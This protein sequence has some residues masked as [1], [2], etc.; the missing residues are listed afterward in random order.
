[1]L[2]CNESYP[3]QITSQD[4]SMYSRIPRLHWFQDASEST[5]ST[6]SSVSLGSSRK[7]THSVV[8]L[9]VHN[10]N[11]TMLNYQKTIRKQAHVCE[12]FVSYNVGQKC[13]NT[14]PQ[15]NVVLRFHVATL[16]SEGGGWCY[17]NSVQ[18]CSH[19]LP[20]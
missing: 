8:N 2:I 18:V 19:H 15:I 16:I 4:V 14:P 20:P 6:F 12:G 1:M 9:H 5:F 10:K 3:E 11:I 7:L 17:N 13:S